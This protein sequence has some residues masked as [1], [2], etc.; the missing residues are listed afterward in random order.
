MLL[1]Q[2]QAKPASCLKSTKRDVSFLQSD[3]RC[4][5]YVSDLSNI[6]PRYLGSKHKGE[7]VVVVDF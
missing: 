5:C 2:H 1:L 3:S 7:V 6:T 4:Q